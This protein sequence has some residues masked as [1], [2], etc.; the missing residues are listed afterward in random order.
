MQPYVILT[1]ISSL[2]FASGNALQKRGIPESLTPMSFVDFFERPSATFSALMRSPLW[3]AGLLATVVAMGVETQ[4]LGQ[5]DVSVVKPLSRVQSVFVVLIAIGFLRERLLPREW[6][7]ITT[8]L[9]GT[10]LLV[11]EPAD[12]TLFAPPSSVTWLAVASLTCGVFFLV[13]LA[14]RRLLGETG[15]VVLAL[16]SGILFGLGDV[17]MKIA[18]EVVKTAAGRFNLASWEGFSSLL[19]AHEFYLSIGSTICAFLLQQVAFSRGRVSVIAP[20]IAVGGTLVTLSMGAYL[21]R[22]PLSLMRLVAIGVMVLGT[23]LLSVKSASDSNGDQ[24]CGISK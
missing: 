8:L 13:K 18:T 7:G 5:G 12:H 14:D 22:E 17:L 20:T 2:L 21:L 9:I 11:Q 15:E 16:A 1:L 23:V 3:A 4:A 6:A 10:A 19:W 24:Q